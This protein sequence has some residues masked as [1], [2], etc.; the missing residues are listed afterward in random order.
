MKVEEVK[1]RNLKS[2]YL[3]RSFQVNTGI[4]SRNSMDGR[5]CD[6]HKVGGSPNVFQSILTSL[7]H[8]SYWA[9]LYKRL[10]LL[11]VYTRRWFNLYIRL[12]TS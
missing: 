7:A 4:L 3:Q 5:A 8:T 1:G 9:S 2:T 11:T 10:G 6:Q 12:F